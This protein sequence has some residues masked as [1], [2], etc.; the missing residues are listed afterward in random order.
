M[1]GDAL[2]SKKNK[3]VIEIK[4]LAF[5]YYKGNAV[6]LRNFIIIKK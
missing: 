1:Q 2:C 4:T 6:S 3:I 5:S